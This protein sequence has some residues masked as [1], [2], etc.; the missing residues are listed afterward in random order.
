MKTYL[1]MADME[2]ESVWFSQMLFKHSE[3]LTA[4]LG[5]FLF[6]KASN[7]LKSRSHWE[8]LNKTT[9]LHQ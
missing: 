8:D 6:L 2:I 4:A 1:R 7:T 3:H 9:L 5:C